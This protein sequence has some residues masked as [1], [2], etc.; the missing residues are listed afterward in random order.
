M[1]R[2]AL[3]LGL[4]ISTAA[5]AQDAPPAPA[6]AAP[7][8]A[9]SQA[10]NAELNAVLPPAQAAM[11]AHVMFLASDAMR[12]RDAGS[13]EYD[14]AA[15][16]VASQFYAAGLRPAGD[17]GS[18]LQKVPLIKVGPADM[19]KLSLN[20]QALTF[21]QDYLPGVNPASAETTLAA[22]VVY[23]GYGVSSPTRDDYAGLD[24]RGKI[25]AVVRGAPSGLDSEEAAHFGGLPTKAGIAR[26]KGAVG[27]IALQTPEV[28]ARMP[29]A[30]TVATAQPTSVT[31]AEADG[32]GHIIGGGVPTLATLSAAGAE[33]L[34]AGSGTSWAKAASAL[35]GKGK[36]RGLTLKPRLDVAIKTVTTPLPSYNVAGILP[37]SDPAVAPETVIL[38]AHLDHV[39]VGTPNK[40]GDTI[41]NG[42]M[43]NAVG[44]ASL[45]EEA[46][47][48][49]AAG[50]APRRSILFLA[51]TAEEK[52]LVGS[53]YFANN[54]TIGKARMV[55]NVNLD[56]PI[57]TYKFSDV[58]AF[59]AVRSSLGDIVKRAATTAGAAFSP[60]PM[61]DMALFVRSD[62]YRFVQQGVPSVFLW[63]GTSGP[64]KAAVDAFFAN[65]YHQP[66]DEVVQ[67]PPIDW[68][69]GERFINVNYQI[70]RDIADAAQR[71]AWNKGDF[72]GT[73]Y[74][75]YGAK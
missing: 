22:P 38:S 66:S 59:G 30:K 75:G 8:A 74:N 29:M 42:A 50:K 17:D 15:N 49:K 5:I 4:L 35:S 32:K 44:I 68:E 1:F 55:A 24:V 12:G 63:P 31:W 65:N 36:F 25:V 10:R 72:F 45:I 70:A 41:Y 43:D 26:A 2:P 16:Y 37:G 13:P 57:I 56:M 46:K 3:L 34:F 52:G 7:T 9:E 53:D 73:L 23:V 27:I 47:R 62:H 28:S 39:G 64:G 51:V 18:Y 58:I 11:K 67:S 61:P 54:P 40:K 71:P 33:K 69:S 19:G 48:F 6:P 14:I 60:D 21:G 20:G